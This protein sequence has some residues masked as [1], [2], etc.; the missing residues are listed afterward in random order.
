MNEWLDTLAHILKLPSQLVSAELSLY[1]AT[2][3]H[4]SECVSDEDPPGW[5]RRD[6]LWTIDELLGLYEPAKRR[7]TLYTKGIGH[8]SERLGVSPDTIRYLVRVHEHAHAVFHLGVD[9]AKSAE[10]AAS[11][12]KDDKTLERET[13]AELSAVFSAVDSYV[14][15]QIAQL[16]TWLVLV[17]LHE[18]AGSE[19]TKEACKRLQETFKK[20]MQR[21]P[22]QYRL[23]GLQHLDE[24]QL[25][26]RLRSLIDLVR[27]GDVRGTERSWNTI[28]TW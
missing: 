24:K 16:I 27:S 1:F 9:Q 6:E 25:R 2:S 20:L 4:P 17:S 11:F 3:M 26:S 23:D 5:G 8:V 28:M 15:E 14:H 10:L 22:P 7:I 18:K 19:P 12:L 13:V 21:Q